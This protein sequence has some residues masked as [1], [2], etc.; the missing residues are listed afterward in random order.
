MRRKIPSMVY[1]LVSFIPWIIHWVLCGL[2]NES[3]VVAAFTISLFLIASQ[4]RKKSFDPM[5][6]TSALYFTIAAAGTF[7]FDLHVFVENSGFLSYI[8]LFLMAVSS[9]FVKQ[10]FTLQVSKRDYPEIYRKDKKYF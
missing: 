7:I 8:A 4:I 5:M 2:G 1:I 6:I 10:P 9:L 3:G